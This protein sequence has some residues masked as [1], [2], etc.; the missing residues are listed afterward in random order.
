MTYNIISTDNVIILTGNVSVDGNFDVNGSPITSGATGPIGATGPTGTA[1]TSVLIV[2]SV[3]TATG[4]NF[5]A[6]DPTPT[7]GDGIIA[8]DTGNLWVY[9]NSVD[10]G[11][12]VGFVD[13]GQIVGPTGATG[14]TGA[15]GPI[16][17]TGAT[18]ATG[19]AST[20]TGPTGASGVVGATGPGYTGVT[21]PTGVRGQTGPTG[22]EGATGPSGGPIGPTGV[23]GSTGPTGPLGT[24]PT[25][26]DGTTG[27]TGPTG[28]T[29]PTGASSVVTGPTGYTGPLGTGPTG[30]TGPTST[31]TGPTGPAYGLGNLTVTD[32]TIAGT[33]VNGNINIDPNGTGKVQLLG[34]TLIKGDTASTLYPS[35]IPGTTVQ[36]QGIDQAATAV[37]IDSHNDA[38]I[39]GPTITMRRFGGSSASP[40][41]VLNNMVLGAVTARG[42]NGAAENSSAWSGL[43]TQAAENY[44]STNMGTRVSIFSV[45]TGS[46]TTV[47]VATFANN[48]TTLGN[49]A[50]SGNA[51]SNSDNTLDLNIGTPGQ[52]GNVLVNGSLQVI[53]PTGNVLLTN[54]SQG[55]IDV[56]SGYQNPDKSS[57]MNIIGNWTR[58]AQF[59][60][61]AGGMLQ[62]TGHDGV[63]SRIINDS[64]GTAVFSAWV[65]RKANGTAISP[66]TTSAG[67]ITRW[68]SSAYTPTLGFNASSVSPGYVEIQLLAT[69]SDTSLPTR[70]A[71]YTAPSGSVTA[72]NV[73]NVDTAGITLPYAG[74][75]ITFPDGSRQTSAGGASN[76]VII[77]GS[78]YSMTNLD[79]FV[80]VNYGAGTVSITLPNSATSAIGTT[81]IVKDTGPHATAQH[82]TINAYAGDTIDGAAS[83][84]I[85]QDWNSYTLLLSASTSWSI[86]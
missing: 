76:V 57:V 70:V 3:A 27:T 4:V 63:S 23:T 54:T 78:T 53:G 17:T 12:I 39:S 35:T 55:Q 79:R 48:T 29:G 86:V 16:G 30:V 14:T 82:I 8:E 56:V 9:T 52:T 40:T 34:N 64:Y 45:P 44:S 5:N 32:Q 26:Y 19:A 42:Y 73:A 84:S 24:G 72:L 83:V 80:G 1:G 38:A 51:V 68:S 59:P 6:L 36:I 43:I 22:V 20:V 2:G 75:G 10:P 60:T 46:N 13:V 11:A 66:T 62:I 58:S 25:G 28:Y 18:G 37:V 47:A 85:T 15:T 77:G 21:G 67:A 81:V 33:V 61:N 74:S 65:G 41:A 50:I 31:V 7:L 71:F 69:A 49:V